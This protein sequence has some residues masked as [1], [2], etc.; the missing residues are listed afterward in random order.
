MEESYLKR[1]GLCE[2]LHLTAI[3]DEIGLPYKCRISD[4]ELVTL[5]LNGESSND[6][7]TELIPNRSLFA[8]SP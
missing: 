5:V 1:A 8:G 3:L 6:R 7:T 2:Q 4:V